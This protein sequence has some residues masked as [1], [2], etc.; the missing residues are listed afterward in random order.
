VSLTILDF[1]RTWRFR[2]PQGVSDRTELTFI[3]AD[4]C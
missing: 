3:L 1:V 4:K 2:P